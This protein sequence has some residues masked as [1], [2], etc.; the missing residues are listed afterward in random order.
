[1][2]YTETVKNPEPEDQALISFR[3][4]QYSNIPLF[5]HPMAFDGTIEL[6]S[7]GNQTKT[8]V[9]LNAYIE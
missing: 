7:I 9:H 2:L 4:T 5:Q 8:C 1:M 6:L 3:Q